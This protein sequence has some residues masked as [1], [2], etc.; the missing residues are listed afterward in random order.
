MLSNAIKFT[1]EG[2]IIVT[3][4]IN[5]KGD[6]KNAIVSVIDNGA[7]MDSEILPKLFAKFASKFFQGTG[8]G[9]FISKSIIEAHDG[10]IWAEN[11]SGGKG[12]TFS[13]SLPITQMW[14]VSKVRRLLELLSSDER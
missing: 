9:L 1:Q 8:L 10:R 4:E 6:N 2:N 11:N 3:T 5:G 12:A 7:G 14:S 13:F